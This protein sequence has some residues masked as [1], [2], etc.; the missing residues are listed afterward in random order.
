MSSH[1]E[2]RAWGVNAKSSGESPRVSTWPQVTGIRANPIV[3]PIS[4]PAESTWFSQ[5]VSSFQSF[6]NDITTDKTEE[7]MQAEDAAA[8][9]ANQEAKRQRILRT[10][11]NEPTLLD[12]YANLVEQDIAAERA[13]DAEVLSGSL[14]DYLP[15]GR[16]AGVA[17]QVFYHEQREQEAIQAARDE[18]AREAEMKKFAAQQAYYYTND[19]M[20]GGNARNM[21]ASRGAARALQAGDYQGAVEAQAK[22]EARN[23]LFGF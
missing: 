1:K 11:R 5:Q 10:I 9:L 19:N 12:K 15:K 22:A 7:E 23:Q 6:W 3:E 8:E 20:I 14:T 2:R 17:G 16:S 21:G 4:E 18:R 13:F